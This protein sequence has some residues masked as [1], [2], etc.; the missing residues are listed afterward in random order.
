[1][2]EESSYA[3]KMD[4]NARRDLMQKLARTETPQAAPSRPAP[5]V[6]PDLIRRNADQYRARQAPA[7]PTAFLLI[8]NMFNPD[9]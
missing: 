3:P 6:L 1:M 5:Y 9:E 4:H 7:Q 8:G 2:V